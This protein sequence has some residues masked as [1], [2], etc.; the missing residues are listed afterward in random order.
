MEQNDLREL[1]ID[2]LRDIYDAENQLVKALPV[3]AEAATAEDLRSGFEVHLEQTRVHVQ[4][5]EQIFNELGMKVK[6]KK[7]KGM[8][9]LVNEGKQMIKDDFK[10]DVKDAGLIS[11]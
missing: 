1:Y 7:C 5:L 2:E 3:M 9:G 4:R 11:A 6:G 8:Q 10:G